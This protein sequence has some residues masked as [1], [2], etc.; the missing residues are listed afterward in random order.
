ASSPRTEREP[1]RVQR[2]AAGL[3]AD[4][5]GIPDDLSNSFRLVNADARMLLLRDQVAQEGQGAFRLRLLQAYE[6]QCA[7]TGEH[8]HPVLDAAHIQPYLGP[9]SNHVQN[10]ILLTK[11]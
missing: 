3:L 2:L 6:G 4:N 7:I 9:T 8:T 1:S 11:E 10:G 5:R